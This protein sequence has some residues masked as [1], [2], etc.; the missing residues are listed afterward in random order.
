M[1]TWSKFKQILIGPTTGFCLFNRPQTPEIKPSLCKRCRKCLSGQIHTEHKAAFTESAGLSAEQI[2]LSQSESMAL[3]VDCR[4]WAHWCHE[5]ASLVAVSGGGTEA[6]YKCPLVFLSSG[7]VE[8][9][10]EEGAL[11]F[12]ERVSLCF[13]LSDTHVWVN[14]LV[15][16]KQQNGSKLVFKRASLPGWP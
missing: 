13:V 10:E 14:S 7:A 16:T 4:M 6:G 8:K 9:E 3:D 15:P 5:K 11:G 1:H 2:V 12:C